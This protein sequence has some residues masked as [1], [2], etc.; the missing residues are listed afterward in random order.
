M[1]DLDQIL[2]QNLQVVRQQIDEA[3]CRSGRSADDIALIAV[4]KYVSADVVRHL[5]E[6]GCRQLGE[7]RPQVLWQKADALSDLS[8]EWHLIG[9]LQR[10]KLRRTLPLIRCLHS[11]D[12]VR[13]LDALNDE[14]HGAGYRPDVLLEVDISREA[15]KTGFAPEEIIPLG[16]RLGQWDALHICGLMA[17]SSRS[18][19][20]AVAR[21]Q[22]AELRQLRDRLQREC[23]AQVDLHQLSMGMSSDFTV[24]IEEGATMVRVGSA[25]LEGVI[26]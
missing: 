7:S 24:A 22:F 1:S 20:R 2:A 16:E 19:D 8:I 14:L 21:R 18:S 12:S 3:A 4:T 13:L 9:H 11:A 23:P 10:N 26:E 25:L 17:M 15:E 6:A 5:V